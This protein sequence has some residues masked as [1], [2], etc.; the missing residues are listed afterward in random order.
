LVLTPGELWLA[1]IEEDHNCGDTAS[2]SGDGNGIP[3]NELY[4]QSAEAP[5][6]SS[7]NKKDDSPEALILSSY[8]D[9]KLM[10]SDEGLEEKFSS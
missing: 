1:E 5:E 4:K 6:E 10:V 9:E 7:Y 8:H 3:I 2:G